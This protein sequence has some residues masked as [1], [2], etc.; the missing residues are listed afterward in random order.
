[1]SPAVGERLGYGITLI[2]ASQFSKAIVMEL[3]PVCD[4]VVWIDLFHLVNEL[5]TFLALFEAVA[6]LS[7]HWYQGEHLFPDWVRLLHRAPA[8]TTLRA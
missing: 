8:A 4:E 2:L 5:F 7:F 6:V 3:V 1:M